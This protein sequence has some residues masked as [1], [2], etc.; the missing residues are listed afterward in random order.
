MRRK[1]LV[2]TMYGSN[3]CFVMPC[4]RLINLHVM[5]LTL[6]VFK[7]CISHYKNSKKWESFPSP[8]Q[9]PEIKCS[10][11]L[12]TIINKKLTSIIPPTTITCVMATKPSIPKFVEQTFTD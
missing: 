7:L 2:T 11:W 9:S 12:L 5:F 8:P 1:Q 10:R 3:K 6:T 4:S